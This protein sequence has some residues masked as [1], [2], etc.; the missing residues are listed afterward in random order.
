MNPSDILIA[1]EDASLASIRVRRGYVS[2]IVDCGTVPSDVVAMVRHIE[3]NY[4]E[5]DG[6]GSL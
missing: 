4:G 6:I 3:R 5:P 2:E 1:I